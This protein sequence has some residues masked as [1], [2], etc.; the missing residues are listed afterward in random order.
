[1]RLLTVWR[2]FN[3][4]PIG[5]DTATARITR[6]FTALAMGLAFYWVKSLMKR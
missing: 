4:K 5:W 6:F 3:R 2:H 1:M